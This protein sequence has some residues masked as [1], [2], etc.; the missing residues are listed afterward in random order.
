VV[1]GKQGLFGGL[2][3]I[4]G[5]PNSQPMLT[6]PGWLREFEHVSAGRSLAP[7]VSRS[8]CRGTCEPLEYYQ[9]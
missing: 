2:P 3:T 7:S 5:K 4:V 8:S 1:G 9:C 6:R